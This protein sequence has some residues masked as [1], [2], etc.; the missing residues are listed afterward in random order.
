MKILILNGPNLNMIGTREPEIYGRQTLAEIETAVKK[1][2]RSLRADIEFKQ[3]NHEGDLIDAIQNARKRHQGVVLNAGGYS[4]T[5]VA[6]RDAIASVDIP[7]VEVHLSNVY[8]R[9]DFRHPSMLAAVC[10]GQIT[11]LGAI[12]YELALLALINFRPAGAQKVEAQPAAAADDDDRR[13]R[14]RTRGGRGRGRTRTERGDG[15]DR[16]D[17]DT[18][19]AE[20]QRSSEPV[21]LDPQ[22]YDHL[23]GVSVRRGVDVLGEDND[24]EPVKAAAGSVS[25]ADE[26]TERRDTSADAGESLSVGGGDTESRESAEDKPAPEKKPRKKRP[27][28][29]KAAPKKAKAAPRRAATSRA[30]KKSS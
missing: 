29:R 27:A 6:L 24:A 15:L 21:E 14:R 17:S 9:E 7:V 5:S 10:I 28:A 11:G 25:F 16:A 4:H 26:D 23:E 13:A 20:D 2:A 1:R 3:S 30:K 8:A 18:G 22:R 19:A 12:G